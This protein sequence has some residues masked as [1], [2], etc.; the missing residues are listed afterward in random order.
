MAVDG[1]LS[2]GGS[3]RL[4]DEV[5]ELAEFLAP[6]QAEAARSGVRVPALWLPV[7][8]FGREEIVSAGT[9]GFAAVIL[10]GLITRQLDIGSQP[11]LELY[12]P[13]DLL[14]ARPLWAGIL[15]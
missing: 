15:P 11:A 6:E 10:D 5:P 8:P 7:G 9:D 2:L 3:A 14:A 12:G 13:G 1:A 4:L